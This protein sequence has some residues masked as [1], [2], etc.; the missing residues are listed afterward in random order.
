MNGTEIS[1]QRIANKAQN[2]PAPTGKPGYAYTDAARAR[3]GRE[4]GRDPARFAE[5]ARTQSACSSREAGGFLGQLSAG[6]T[7]PEFEAALAT[8]AE[9]TITPE[10]VRTRHGFHIIRRDARAEGAALPF[11][12]VE[13]KLREAHMMAAWVRG[14][15]AFIAELVARA[16]IS[17]VTMEPA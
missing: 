15:R 16:E 10:P 4:L 2:H 9:G 5:L 11:E 6:D 14:A 7:V 17:G 8:M 1:A 3:A 13:P 12:S